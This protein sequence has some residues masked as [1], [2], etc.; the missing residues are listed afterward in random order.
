MA[1]AAAEAVP[2]AMAAAAVVPLVAL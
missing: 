1:M 2:A